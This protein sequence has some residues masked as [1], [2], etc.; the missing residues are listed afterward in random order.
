MDGK[1]GR[2]ADGN[3]QERSVP[4]TATEVMPEIY[5]NN[6]WD[7]GSFGATDHGKLGAKDHGKS[8]VWMLF[9]LGSSL[10]ENL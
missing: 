3:V 1:E 2:G 6:G 9:M 8:K 10:V 4:V 7:N 5:G